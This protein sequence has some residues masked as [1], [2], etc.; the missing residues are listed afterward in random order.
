[1][2][3]LHKY[4]LRIRSVSR[5]DPSRIEKIIIKAKKDGIKNIVIYIEDSKTFKIYDTRVTGGLSQKCCESFVLGK[6]FEYY[7]AF[8]RLFSLSFGDE[9]AFYNNGKGYPGIDGFRFIVLDLSKLL[10][11]NGKRKIYPD[12]YTI[13]KLPMTGHEEYDLTEDKK[14]IDSLTGS[15]SEPS[16]LTSDHVVPQ[17]Y[18]YNHGGEYWPIHKMIKFEYSLDNHVITKRTTNSGKRDRGPSE[19]LP[20][21][22]EKVSH[23]TSPQDYEQLILGYP[24]SQQNLIREI[25]EDYCFIWDKVSKRYGIQ[26][27]KEDQ[28]IIQF[29]ISS[30]I[31]R[32]RNP[33]PIN[34]HYRSPRLV[35]P[36]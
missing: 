2:V 4:K 10:I 5:E 18:A 9:F 33:H 23:V 22:E 17:A 24:K 19:W 25:V 7:Y 29:V 15:K 34:P 20:I 1:M 11:H 8:R 26:L 16:E 14:L 12:P 6:L 31:N 28:D 21:L 32:G 36:R 13:Y 3:D 27:Q 35:W 30:A